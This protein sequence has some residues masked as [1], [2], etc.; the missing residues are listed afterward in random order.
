MSFDDLPHPIQIKIWREY[1]KDKKGRV[2]AMIR[3]HIEK[4]ITYRKKHYYSCDCDFY[5][6]HQFNHYL[7]TIPSKW[8]RIIHC[9][10]QCVIQCDNDKKVEFKFF[11]M[12]GVW[13]ILLIHSNNSECFYCFNYNISKLFDLICINDENKLWVRNDN[14]NDPNY[15]IGKMKNNIQSFL[16]L[17]THATEINLRLQFDCKVEA[18]SIIIKL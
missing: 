13:N 5:K 12:N 10:I 14:W 6:S 3:K 17:L 15:S 2:L 4:Y 16:N 8:G 7:Y 9:F 1:Y 18:E 11:E